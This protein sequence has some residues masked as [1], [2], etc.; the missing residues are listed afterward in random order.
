MHRVVLLFTL[1]FFHTSAISK[2]IVGQYASATF[3]RTP[4]VTSVF[5]HN[6]APF[7][8]VCKWGINGWQYKSYIPSGTSTIALKFKS[9]HYEMHQ[10]RW[11]CVKLN[12]TVDKPRT[13]RNGN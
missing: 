12:R 13:V 10:M 4:D 7:N 5:L 6:I 8:I 1:L 9:A 11:F 3:T 2:T